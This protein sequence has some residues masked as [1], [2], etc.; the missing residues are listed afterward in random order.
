MVKTLGRSENMVM[1]K[2]AHKTM[3]SIIA[4]CTVLF[5]VQLNS[6]AV[7]YTN[8]PEAVVCTSH[9]DMKTSMGFA[10][11][12]NTEITESIIQLRVAGDSQDFGT[13]PN[14]TFTGT[15]ETVSHGELSYN[16]H[17]VVATGL[18]PGTKYEY[19]VGAQGYWSD[20][21]ESLNSVGSFE[22]APEHEEEFTFINLADINAANEDAMRAFGN[23]LQRSVNL[24]PSYKFIVQNGDTVD[25]T[26]D[27]D[28]KEQQWKWFFQYAQHILKNT[29]WVSAIGNHD[30]APDDANYNQ[31]FNFQSVGENGT[32]FSFDY[33]NVHF[34]VLDTNV[35][36][37]KQV[38]WALYDVVKN[39][40]KW[41]IAVFHR[42]L[43]SN[44]SHSNEATIRKV[45]S[46]PLCDMLG[47]D[48]IL[49]GHDHV[50]NRGYYLKDG[51]PVSDSVNK[52]EGEEN[53]VT[54]PIG[55]L[56]V[57]PNCAATKFYTPN[58]D[59][60]DYIKVSAQPKK[61]TYAGVTVTNDTLKYKVYYYDN[62]SNTD[63]LLD[64]F[65]MKKTKKPPLPPKNVRTVFNRETKSATLTWEVSSTENVRGYV[66]YDENNQYIPHWTCFINDPDVR[67]HIITGLDKDK[68]SQYKFVVKAVGDK[69]FSEA[70]IPEATVIDREISNIVKDAKLVDEAG[71]VL[72]K[73]QL[74]Q[75]F[76]GRPITLLLHK[77][78]TGTITK[79]DIL[80]ID[81]TTVKQDGSYIFK[82]FINKDVNEINDYQLSMYMEDELVNDSVTL[83][84]VGYS[85][86]DAT[87]ELLDVNDDTVSGKLVI[88]NYFNI[89]GL[90]YTICFAF[91]DGNNKLLGVQMMDNVKDIN[92]EITIGYL[93][94][95]IPSGTSGVKALV[96]SNYTQLIPLCNDYMEIH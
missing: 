7:T 9:G 31:H 34:L 90:T 1:F 56:F 33:S 16:V 96:W 70:G 68:F 91:Y 81:Q 84:T 87:V 39:N 48:L 95:S 32:Y 23:S 44:G 80:H 12:T 15:C 89:E 17:K 78:N 45:W 85:W 52:E 25:N 51:L 61:S 50:Y 19:R 21:S 10:W 11:Y 30:A 46:K 93:S 77:K 59:N 82:F 57:L 71:R 73:G 76:A 38:D 40:K 14:L 88:N 22:T 83:A 8:Y 64:Q 37:Q 6:L 35:N 47:I 49:T 69:S 4:F 41:N 65:G 63:V 36:G 26:K 60:S 54:D 72:V 20:A 79:Q 86:L 42:P 67:S 43:Y 24:F 13:D 94:S 29:I 28:I 53:I 27:K 74:D 92:Q 18:Q 5:V 2:K 66:I 58:D 75:S 55:T 3:V 62:S